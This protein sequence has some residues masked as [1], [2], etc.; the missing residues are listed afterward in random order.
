MVIS[1][2]YYST[3]LIID[4]QCMPLTCSQNSGRY[5]LLAMNALLSCLIDNIAACLTSLC[6][7]K[8]CP[9]LEGGQNHMDS[10]LESTEDNPLSPSYNTAAGLGSYMLYYVRHCRVARLA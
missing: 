3:D 6:G 4:L 9:S 1:H 8:L 7:S 5:S 2:F 10:C